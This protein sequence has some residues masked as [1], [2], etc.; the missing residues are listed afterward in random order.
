M[1]FH[2]LSH[3]GDINHIYSSQPWKSF[4]TNDWKLGIEIL[5]Y[6]FII[7]DLFYLYVFCLCVYLYSKYIN[8]LLRPEERIGP[9]RL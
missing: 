3:E 5:C 6:C 4:V 7:I 1:H 8:C 9:L 2:I